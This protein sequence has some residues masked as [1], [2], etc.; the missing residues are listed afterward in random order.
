MLTHAL[1]PAAGPLGTMLQQLAAQ[2]TAS[3]QPPHRWVPTTCITAL[4]P[5][6]HTYLRALL[7]LQARLAPCCSAACDVSAVTSCRATIFTLSSVLH[8][9]LQ[10]N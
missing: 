2:R 1:L 9:L 4:L 5:V 10:V 8:G 6:W 7:L 3:L